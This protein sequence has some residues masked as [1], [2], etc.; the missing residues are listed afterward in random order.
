MNICT[1]STVNYGTKHEYRSPVR[2]IAHFGKAVD[3]KLSLLHQNNPLFTL[4]LVQPPLYN[5]LTGASVAVGNKA[6]KLKVKLLK[7]GDFELDVDAGSKVSGASGGRAARE[8][9]GG[10]AKSALRD[11]L[12]RDCRGPP[13][14]NSVHSCTGGRKA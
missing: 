7:G 13:V 14:V 8:G 11:A 4:D 9:E 12:A 2:S 5:P 10:G 3:S 1:G 6:M